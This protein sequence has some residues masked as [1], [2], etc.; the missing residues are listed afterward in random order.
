MLLDFSDHTNFIPPRYRSEVLPG[1]TKKQPGE[2][3]LVPEHSHYLMVDDG[4]RGW[5]SKQDYELFQDKLF[6]L[7][8]VIN[9][10]APSL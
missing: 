8:R 7:F 5:Y 3:F 9:D 6:G 4:N 1:G 2:H 10:E